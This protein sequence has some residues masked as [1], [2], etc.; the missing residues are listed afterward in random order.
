MVDVVRISLLAL[1]TDSRSLLTTKTTLNASRRLTLFTRYARDFTVPKANAQER[2]LNLFLLDPHIRTPKNGPRR[3][4]TTLLAVASSPAIA[5]SPSTPVRSGGWSLHWK[6]S[7][8]QMTNKN[9]NL[10]KS[11]LIPSMCSESSKL[12]SSNAFVMGLNNL[13]VF[14][15][16]K[17]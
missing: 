2:F 6:N 16:L 7:P 13:L 3:R 17:I 4:F 1:C 9:L 11:A 12:Q 8:L 10:H 14:L 5:P 15:Y